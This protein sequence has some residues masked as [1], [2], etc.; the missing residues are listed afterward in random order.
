MQFLMVLEFMKRKLFSS[1]L[2]FLSLFLFQSC[3]SFSKQESDVD[4]PLPRQNFTVACS[5]KIVFNDFFETKDEENTI[6][7]SLS[8]GIKYPIF[9]IFVSFDEGRFEKEHYKAIIKFDDKTEKIKLNTIKYYEEGKKVY[10]LKR[11]KAFGKRYIFNSAFYPFDND[12]NNDFL[13]CKIYDK[14]G[15]YKVFCRDKTFTYQI[16]SNNKIMAYIFDDNYEIYDVSQEKSMKE[17]IAA[18]C[19]VEGYIKT[20]KKSRWKQKIF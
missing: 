6:K 10:F 17:I 5:G 1:I 15:T 3:V 16:E 19:A 20:N 4:F 7:I 12:G 8:R 14:D 9:S 18:I 2:I 13:L 11:M